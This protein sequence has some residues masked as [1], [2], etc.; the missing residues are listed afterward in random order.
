PY[1]FSVATLDIRK[2]FDHVMNCFAKYS[3]SQHGI[4]TNC[5]LVLTGVSGWQDRKFKKF[6]SGLPKKVKEKIIFTGYVDD[7]DLPLLYSGAAC[8][9][10][11]S[12]YEG[13]GLPPLEA[14]Q[15]GTPVITSNTSSLPE[16]VGDA[17]IM[18]DPYD[19]DGLTDAF[20]RVLNN[21]TLRNSMIANG[22]E[23][24]QKFNWDNCVNS[25]IEQIIP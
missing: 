8:F 7:E 5:H 23:Q 2:N 14:M 4:E 9:C 13:F 6:F 11:M 21:E 19:I 12:I 18:L 15:C 10:Y 1:I 3:S 17:G 20:D 24:A 25:I 22:L 16:V